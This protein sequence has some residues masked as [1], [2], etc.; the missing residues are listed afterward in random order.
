MLPTGRAAAPPS[1][2]TRWFLL[3]VVGGTGGFILLL[4]LGVIPWRPYR[5]CRAVFCDPYH[6]QVACFGVAFLLAGVACVIPSRQRVLGLL[7]SAGLVTAL[8]AGAVG[9]IMA[10]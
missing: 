8:I 10:R 3:L 1:A 9:T 4:Y 6:W 5:G 7:C 2:A